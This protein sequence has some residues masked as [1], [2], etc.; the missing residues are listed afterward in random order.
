M[1][2]TAGKRVSVD[3]DVTEVRMVNIQFNCHFPTDP[4]MI[5]S[6]FLD[7]NGVYID[8]EKIGYMVYQLNPPLKTK[9]DNITV[10]FKTYAQSGTILDF[11]TNTGDHWGIKIVRWGSDQVM[12]SSNDVDFEGKRRGRSGALGH[13]L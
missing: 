6:S 8:Y 5:L 7:V 1:F 2:A 3:P 10:G 13:R 12:E 9:E 4:A 11:V